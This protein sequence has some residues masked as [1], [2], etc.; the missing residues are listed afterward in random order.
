VNKAVNNPMAPNRSNGVTLIELII[1][2]AIASIIALIGAPSLSKIVKDSRL[3]LAAN[4]LQNSFALARSTSVA[5]SS[6]VTI[7]KS[8]DGTS[9]TTTG[10]WSQGWMIF[11][12]TGT[13]GDS[14][15]DTTT[16]ADGDQRVRVL[17]AFDTSV[18]M[19]GSDGLTSFVSFDASG[20][21]RDA[22]NNYQSGSI[23]VCDERGD[24]GRARAVYLGAAGSSRV[25][26]LAGDLSCDG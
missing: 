23:I 25:G 2:L 14:S 21:T 1:V 26:D 13:I 22:S 7:C 19:T 16:D 9:C 20:F 24:E 17:Q 11:E 4:S 5:R 18:L 3:R 8:S 12:D 10:D 15:D 6:N